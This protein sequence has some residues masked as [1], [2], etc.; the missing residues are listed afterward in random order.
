MTCIVGF[1]EGDTIWMGGDSAGVS[2]WD[3]VIRAD[4]KVFR[5]GPMVLGFTTSFRMGQLLRHA[6]TIPDRPASMDLD[7]YMVTVFVDAVRECLKSK[8][9]AEKTNEQEKGGE[10]LVGYESRLFAVHADYQI[11]APVSQCYAIGS[12]GPFAMGALVATPHLKGRKRIEGAL[13]AAEQCS[14]GVRGPFHVEALK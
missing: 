1:V 10:F 5:N 9:W 8:G 2:G 4:Q 7:K 13:K 6:L 11:A 12:G 3:L 14:A